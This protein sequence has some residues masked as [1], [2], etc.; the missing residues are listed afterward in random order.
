MFAEDGGTIVLADW[1]A[2]SALGETVAAQLGFWYDPAGPFCG[3]KGRTR[4]AVIDGLVN[5]GAIDLLLEQLDEREVL[6]VCGTGLDPEAA[7]YL[8][9]QRLGSSAQLI[10]AAILSA[11]GRPRRWAPALKKTEPVLAE[12]RP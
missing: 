4:L 3:R 1:A 10:P 7:T 11:Y 5:T 9:S 2:G 8:S 12:T 6:L